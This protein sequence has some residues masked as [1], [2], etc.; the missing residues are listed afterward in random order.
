MPAYDHPFTCKFWYPLDATYETATLALAIKAPEIGN[1]I[2]SGRNQSIFR[3]ANGGVKVYDYGN[4][5]STEHILDFKSIPDTERAALIQFL[6]FVG[7]GLAVVKYQDYIGNTYNVRVNQN[8][9]NLS[10]TGYTL[11]RDINSNILWDF[12]LKILEVN[13]STQSGSLMSTALS[14]HIADYN[15]PHT[16]TTTTTV[17]VADVYQV[18]DSVESA[19][20]KHVVFLVVGYLASGVTQFS[21]LV[22]VD[23]IA[24][25]IKVVS[26]GIG[27]LPYNDSFDV[28]LAATT[29]QLKFKNSPANTTL[30]TIKVKRIKV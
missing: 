22:T 29:L 25:D 23:I 10:D 4:T 13:D 6:E 14:A 30:A 8:S 16:P 2:S 15:T 17:G 26:E 21:R 18:I 27:A 20:M 3:T 1:Q 12:S 7:W 5:L 19:V 11:K 24:S 9:L 28:E